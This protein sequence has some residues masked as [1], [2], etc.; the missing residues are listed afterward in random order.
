MQERI[1]SRAEFQ[2]QLIELQRM[3]SWQVFLSRLN[4]SK[5]NQALRSRILGTAS[6][7]SSGRAS[8]WPGLART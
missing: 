5:A 7:T 2:V 8:R 4:E 6:E 1:D 3:N